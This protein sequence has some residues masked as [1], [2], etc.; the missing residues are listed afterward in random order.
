MPLTS[1]AKKFPVIETDADIATGAEFLVGREPC[2]EKVIAVHGLPSSRRVENCLAS[3][4]K[5]VTEQLISLTAADAIW[6][7]I[8]S[9]L[10]PFEPQEILKF[11]LEDL[12]GL[13]LTRAKAR[14][15]QA[16]AM[17]IDSGELNLESLHEVPD[18]EILGK[19][20]A[21]PGIG[22]W[23]AE[24]YLLTALGRADACP[25]GDLALQVA[26][27]DLFAMD[28]RPT[29]KVFLERAET[30]KPWRSVAARLL[31]S[32]YRGLKGLSQR[33]N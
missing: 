10:H 16:I 5:I 25:A 7:R 24:I 17:A 1:D 23:T 8:E 12:Q 29:P 14:S 21:L 3:L 26:A 4:L 20:V 11:S 9:R 6:R 27:Q 19:L 22:T 30:W 13:G 31:W 28:S 18:Q 33:V 32:H 15:F 2:F